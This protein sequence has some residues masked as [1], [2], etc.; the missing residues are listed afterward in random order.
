[1]LASV[2]VAGC[3]PTCGEACYKLTQCGLNPD[4]G[5]LECETACRRELAA[6]QDDGNTAA[7]TAFDAMRSCLGSSTCDEIE[8]GEC[9]D[10]AL[11]AFES[12]PAGG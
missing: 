11:F 1:M 9:Y 6:Y 3:P 12:S 8:L 7:E 4:V 5:Q 2:L 10:P